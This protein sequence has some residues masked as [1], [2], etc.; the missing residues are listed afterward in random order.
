MQ[1]R[2]AGAIDGAIEVDYRRYRQGIAD[3]VDTG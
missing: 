3:K 2:L 1:W